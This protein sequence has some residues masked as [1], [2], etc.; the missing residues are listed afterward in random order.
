LGDVVN[1]RQA[2][3]RRDRAEKA[4]QAAENRVRHGRSKA[5]RR[6]E[7]AE[8]EHTDRSFEGHKVTDGEPPGK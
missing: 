3:K 6:R 7:A 1:L 5:E 4:R 2:R 8:H